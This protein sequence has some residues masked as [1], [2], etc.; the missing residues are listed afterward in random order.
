AAFG[1]AAE[2]ASLA[3]TP[4]SLEVF[5]RWQMVP[6]ALLAHPDLLGAVWPAL[7][8]DYVLVRD[9]QFEKQERLRCPIVAFGGVEDALV[10]RDDLA[11]W[12]QH[13]EADFSLELLAGGH[14]FIEGQRSALLA[15][16]ETHLRKVS[17]Q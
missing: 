2:S 9:Y 1:S 7:R 3:L 15:A 10:S 5:R 17:D 11:L 8:A 4:G 6:D 14:L 12:C 16:I 13:T